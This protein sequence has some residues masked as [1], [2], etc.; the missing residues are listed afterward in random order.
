M[1]AY[2]F[3]NY[4]N[5]TNIEHIKKYAESNAVLCFDFEDSI[6]ISEKDNYRRYFSYIIKNIL[7]MLPSTRIGLRINN[8][9]EETNKDLEASA[10]CH[11]NS[12]ILP[13]I[14]TYEEIKMFENLL[15]KKNISYD[16]IIP[17]I[18]NKNGLSNLKLIVK[19]SNPKIKRYGFGHCDYNL[20]IN[21]FPFFH[22]D[23]IEYWKWVR[24]LQSILVPRK[25]SILHSPYLELG[26]YSFF[27]SMLHNLYNI[28]GNDVA[29]TTLTSKQSI[30]VKDF[31]KETE[32]FPFNK[33]IKHRL[34]LTVPEKYAERIITS[35]NKN[36]KRKAFSIL[37]KNNKLVSPQEYE[38]ATNY[39][40]LKRKGIINLTFVGG[41]FPVQNDILFED[42]GSDAFLVDYRT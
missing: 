25:L 14:E 16:E 9:I 3:I 29:Q 7:P 23:S 13:K 42:L 26:N 34:N 38:A 31:V 19:A 35:F 37:T 33:L 30:L 32:H 39:I 27:Q 41:C 8:D 5:E 2:Q 4:N 1:L 12:I 40:G 6:K 24:Q 20:S 28:F 22:Q 18:E 36:K 10:N 17:T 11:I 21:A 15:V